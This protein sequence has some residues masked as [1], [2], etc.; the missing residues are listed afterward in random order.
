[1]LSLLSAN[2]NNGSLGNKYVQKRVFYVLEKEALWKQE[3]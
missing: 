1:M 2:G 3:L